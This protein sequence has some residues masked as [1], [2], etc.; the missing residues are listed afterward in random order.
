MG[1]QYYKATDDV[2]D[3]VMEVMD[4]YHEHL[5]EARFGILFVDV[6]PVKGTMRVMGKAKKVSAEQKALLPYDFLLIFSHD[7]W[8]G[9]ADYQKRAL[10]DHELCHCSFTN[11][12]ASI[13]PHDFEEFNVIIERH[14]FWWPLASRTE[15]IFQARLALDMESRGVVEAVDAPDV[16]DQVSDMM[17]DDDVEPA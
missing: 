14:G 16:L 1:K 9:L 12:Q 7:V 2:V 6:A 3:L 15:R 17:E 10:V 8:M 13:V 4:E 5:M 11:E